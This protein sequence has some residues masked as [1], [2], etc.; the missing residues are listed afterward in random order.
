M[1]L[2]R[3][4]T[5]CQLL[6]LEWGNYPFTPGRLLY[7]LKQ[8]YGDGWA[9]TYY[10]DAIR[11]RILATPSIRTPD[12][13][14]EI[15]V[16]TS[17]GDWL[18]LLWALKSFYLHSGRSYA[19]CIHDDGTLPAEACLAL[20][21]AFPDARLISRDE[22][23]RRLQPLLADCPR[24]S[25]LRAVN[26]LALKVFDFAAFLEGQRMMIMDSDIL[27]FSKPEALL[28]A[29]EGCSVNTLNQ[30]WRYGYTIGP[31]T[32]AGLAFHLPPLINSGLGL[33]HRESIRFDW[34]EEFL[35]LPD[36]LS[37]PHQI[38]QTLIALCS[39]RFGFAMLPPDY[40]VHT[41]PMRAGD[42]CRHYAGPTRPLLYREGM[43]TL[44]ECGFLKASSWP[45]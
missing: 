6:R 19:L 2:S 45:N 35:G 32:I 20:R 29:L 13:T 39:A 4:N 27:F 28:T 16:L 34:I 26:T 25:E 14:C 7:L 33:I 44:C 18:N 24:S 36:I 38:E 5:L 3:S 9:V 23:D 15:H 12:E 10:R 43:R 1:T 31:E 8:K 40:D 11:P 42:P 22:A 21:V 30:D 37:H 17:Q 41:G